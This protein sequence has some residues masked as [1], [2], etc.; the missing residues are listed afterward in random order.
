[1]AVSFLRSSIAHG[2]RWPQDG[3]PAVAGRRGGAGGHAASFAAPHSHE[4]GATP[5]LA[6]ALARTSTGSPTTF[7]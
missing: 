1:M 3:Q 2:T 4:N 6:K 5:K 7:Q